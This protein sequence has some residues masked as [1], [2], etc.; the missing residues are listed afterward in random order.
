MAQAGA[1]AGAY[2]TTRQIG[3]VLG[4]AGI[5]V[6]M[7]TRLNSLLPG[8]ASADSEVSALPVIFFAAPQRG[9][10]PPGSA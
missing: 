4:S 7:Q 3:V 9:S 10:R 8:S 2:N 1:G 5:A 6:L